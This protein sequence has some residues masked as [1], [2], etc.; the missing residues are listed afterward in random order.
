M[1]WQP[2]TFLQSSINFT[3]ALPL[4]FLAL[5]PQ[6]T[7]GES[8]RIARVA[9]VS[10]TVLEGFLAY[11][12]AGAYTSWAA[13]L[14]LPVGM[15][16]VH[17]GFKEV[18]PYAQRTQK[19]RLQSSSLIAVIGIVFIIAVLLLNY[20]YNDFNGA[21]S[22]YTS[23]RSLA[24]PGADRIHLP[25]KEERT[26][27]SLSHALRANC[28][29]F[30]SMPGLDSFYLFTS[31]DPPSMLNIGDWMYF[32]DDS[33]QQQVLQSLRRPN[34]EKRLCVLVNPKILRFWQAGR[35]LPQGPL[36]RFVER[37][38]V[39]HGLPERFQGYELFVPSHHSTTG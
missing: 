39:Q 29:T 23:E 15:L 36:V 3:A 20:S 33:Q 34:H 30:I 8:E 13:L 21:M 6:T 26:F 28:S 14:L 25:T 22:T 17:D 4:A 11:P 10:I 2:G 37:Y 35:Q 19:D 12:D 18:L 27:V 9:L 5:V 31:Q 7:L 38:E 24:L 16:I 1:T 32:F